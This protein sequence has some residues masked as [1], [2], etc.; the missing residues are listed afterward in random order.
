MYVSLFSKCL[1]KIFFLPTNVWRMLF[2]NASCKVLLLFSV[3]FLQQYL[4]RVVFWY[5]TPASCWFLVWLTLRLWRWRRYDP[6]K[7][8]MTLTGLRTSQSIELPTALAKLFTIV[9]NENPPSGSQLTNGKTEGGRH[10]CNFSLQTRQKETKK[11]TKFEF[12]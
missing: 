9:F 1:F 11:E 7:R 12:L 6:P 4:W 8:R 5:I 3:R 10:I 2:K